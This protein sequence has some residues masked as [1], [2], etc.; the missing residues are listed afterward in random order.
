MKERMYT[1][2]VYSKYSIVFCI[3]DVVNNFEF[4]SK[5]RRRISVLHRMIA[6]K[7]H[8]D[9]LLNN[10]FL[11]GSDICHTLSINL[12]PHMKKEVLRISP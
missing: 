4:V 8:L 9:V 3:Y 12:Q 1:F 7:S 11:Y 6:E 10:I 2:E 5:Y